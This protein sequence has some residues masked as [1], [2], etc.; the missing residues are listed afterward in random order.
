MKVT[1][2]Q[3][4]VSENRGLTRIFGSKRTWQEVEEDCIMKSIIN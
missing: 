2:F 3:L 4:R 1:F